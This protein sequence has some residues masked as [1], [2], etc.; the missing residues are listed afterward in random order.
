VD[1][2]AQYAG[3]RF[4]GVAVGRNVL[5]NETLNSI[6]CSGAAVEERR[7]IRRDHMPG[8]MTYIDLDQFG[9]AVQGETGRFKVSYAI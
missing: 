8:E 7:H 4:I 9:R 2:L 3:H 1:P 5:G 6:A